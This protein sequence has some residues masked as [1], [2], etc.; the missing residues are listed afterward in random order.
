MTRSRSSDAGPSART[1]ALYANYAGLKKE[2]LMGT[3]SSPTKRLN[4]TYAPVT[5][6]NE[7]RPGAIRGRRL[8]RDTLGFWVGG[9]ALG[10]AGGILGACVPS[11][12]P[13]AVVLGV[14]WWGLYLGCLGAALGALCG[15]FTERD[16]PPAAQGSDRCA[17]PPA[18]MN[19]SLPSAPATTDR[20][21]TPRRGF[22]PR[23]QL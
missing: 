11:R 4:P 23:R 17:Q 19:N 14:L 5:T 20:S 15:F 12:Y 16:P 6:G 21:A 7:A 1:T 3:M 22:A 2:D 13:V 18:E 8:G 9:V 10:T